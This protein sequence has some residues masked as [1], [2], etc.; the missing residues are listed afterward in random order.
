M[1]AKC[2]CL[3]PS[4]QSNLFSQSQNVVGC[5][6]RLTLTRKWSIHSAGSLNVPGL[7]LIKWWKKKLFLLML[8]RYAVLPVGFNFILVEF[9][10][11]TCSSFH[12]YVTTTREG[13]DMSEIRTLFPVIS[14]RRI[15]FRRAFNLYCL[16]YEK[17]WSYVFLS[18]ADFRCLHLKGQ[19]IKLN[20]DFLQWAAY[21]ETSLWWA[22]LFSRTGE[23][24]M[25]QALANVCHVMYVTQCVSKF[26][27]VAFGLCL[28]L[29]KCTGWQD[30]K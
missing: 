27:E 1:E 26:M 7:C 11:S 21:N 25:V 14:S 24:K 28:C 12:F 15:H 18:D 30:R 22:S 20:K 29:T 4:K 17:T 2:S 16:F 13:L 6:H 23:Q 3:E 19:I 9:T 8:L 10:S 5:I